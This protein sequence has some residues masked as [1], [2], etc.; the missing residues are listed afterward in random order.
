[1]GNIKDGNTDGSGSGNIELEIRSK[2]P[3]LM[4]RKIVAPAVR[5]IILKTLPPPLISWGLGFLWDPGWYI[6]VFKVG[7]ISEIG[8]GLL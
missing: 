3:R 8:H 4:G 1:M 7:N 6:L 5:L 2:H